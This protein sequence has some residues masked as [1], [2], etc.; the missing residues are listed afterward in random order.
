MRLRSVP[1]VA[2]E[3]F[4]PSR[5]PGEPRVVTGLVETWLACARWTPDYLERTAGDA[6]VNVLRRMGPPRNFG[7]TDAEG[8]S[9]AFRE[10]LGWV[11]ETSAEY[12][13]LRGRTLAPREIVDMIEEAGFEESYSLDT[14]LA[15]LSEALVRDVEVPRW[16]AAAPSA[17]VFWC[18]IFGNSSGLHFDLSPNCNVQVRG[19]KHFVLFAPTQT[20]LLYRYPQPDAHCA[21]DPTR[22]DFERFPRARRRG[23]GVHARGAR[24]AV[25]PD[26]LV[27]P[28]HGRLALGAERE[29]LVAPPIPAR[30]R[31]AERVAAARVAHAKVRLVRVVAAESTRAVRHHAR[32]KKKGRPP[33]SPSRRTAAL[34]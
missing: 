24:G 13:A 26:G 23:M 34:R 4:R 10:Y 1:R 18:S 6:R 29:L 31:H 15:S 12:E 28:G 3:E 7:Q 33:W 30:A 11:L 20:R 8:G 19:R 21:F 22:P 14:P 9:V 16:Y 2:S 32:G 25:P 27:P 5:L 17:I